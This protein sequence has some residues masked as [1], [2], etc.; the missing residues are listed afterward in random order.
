MPFTRSKAKAEASAALFISII[1]P[2]VDSGYIGA[3]EIGRIAQMSKE[4]QAAMAEDS[5]WASLCRREYPNTESFLPVFLRQKGRYLWLYK[6][7]ACPVKKESRQLSP[8]SAPPSCSSDEILLCV[9]VKMNGRSILNTVNGADQ[10]HYLL[11][12]G[13]VMA[14]SEAPIVI[15]KVEWDFTEEQRRDFRRGSATR[16]LLPV[17]CKEFDG[18]KIDTRVHVY[19]D[20][21]GEPSMCCIFD[22]DGYT[23]ERSMRARPLVDEGEEISN[24]TKFDTDCEFR[25]TVEIKKP[26]NAIQGWPLRDSDMANAIQRRLGCP[27]FLKFWLYLRVVEDDMLA[28]TGFSMEACKKL[29]PDNCPRFNS[30]E[31]KKKH[32]VTLLHILS[33][34][35]DSSL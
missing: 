24:E 10:Y 14:K 23:L 13:T 29:G 4:M 33:E 11:E 27:I 6:R 25:N 15:G 2:L 30:Q 20:V 16:S 22:S 12:T 35:Q 32:G 7:F 18:K 17:R 8:L 31:E 28:I 3:K 26:F 5:I 34:L 1:Q 9:D 19:R 21:P